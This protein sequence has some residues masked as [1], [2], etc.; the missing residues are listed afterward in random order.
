M[1][2]SEVSH[3]HHFLDTVQKRMFEFAQPQ[4]RQYHTCGK[5]INT[6]FFICTLSTVK[7]PGSFQSMALVRVFRLTED[8]L[9]IRQYLGLNLD[10]FYSS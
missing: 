8:L 2:R 7:I 10:N 4:E 3:L 9:S 5:K 1:A 6:T